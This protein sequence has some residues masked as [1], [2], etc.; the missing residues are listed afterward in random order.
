MIKYIPGLNGIRAIAVFLVILSHRFPVGHIVHVFPL[1]NYGVD[2]FFVLSGFLISRSL[3]FQISNKEN[4]IPHLKILKRFFIRRCLRIFP[5]YYLLLLFMYLTGGI[6]G[7]QFRENILWYVFYGANHLNYNE[8]RWF[9]SLAHL[10]SLSVEEQF[11]I[12]WPLLLLFV[13]KKRILLLIELLIIVGTCAP[14]LYN[15]LGNIL[16]IS[17]V[18]AF[19]IGALLAYV[20]IIRPDYEILFVKISKLIFLPLVLLVCIHNTVAAI[21]YFSERLAISLL[22]VTIIG[23][24]RYSTK[25]TLVTYILGNKVLNF[26][27]IISYGIYLYHNIVPKYWVWGLQK[28]SWVTPA[29]INKFS[30]LEFIIQTSFIIGISYLS[31]IIVEK[32][33]LRLK[34]KIK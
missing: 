4:R 5:I 13:F 30:Y 25:N 21:P 33:I 10:W 29:S 18:N 11:Y 6:I 31:W 12:F 17:C 14:F 15:G 22:A 2:F 20:E 32:P 7:N 23:S 8:N 1:G 27:G 34:E 26:I 28:M 9:G 24:C 16:T 19:G 3:L